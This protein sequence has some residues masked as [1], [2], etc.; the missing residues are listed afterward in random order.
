MI[1]PFE[2]L[3]PTSIKE[4]VILGKTYGAEAKYIAGGTDVIVGMKNNPQESPRFLI[5]LCYLQEKLNSFKVENG[6]LI[7]GALTTHRELEKSALIKKDYQVLHD[8]VSK[9]GSVQIRNVGTI[10]GNICS[11]L[12]S[13]DTASP[14][15]AL[16]AKLKVSG[17]DGER[18]IPLEDFYLGPGQNILNKEDILTEI[19]VP[20]KSPLTAGAYNKL[21]RRGAMELAM[22]GAAVYLEMDKNLD[23]CLNARVALTTSAPVPML[24]K[25]AAKELIGKQ[26]TPDSLAKAGKAAAQEAS[27]RT[28]FRTTAEYRR[29]V[30]PV[31]VRRSGL[32]ALERIKGK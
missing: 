32:T 24:A 26:I 19:I 1:K 4:A 18:I 27:P 31:L 2:Y 30:I 22:A 14:L 6:E 9:V 12:P 28:S 10:G 20:A 16:G 3:R 13:A 5:T 8:A 25:Q 7:I 29:D 15:L 11:S 21:G 17:A 23:L